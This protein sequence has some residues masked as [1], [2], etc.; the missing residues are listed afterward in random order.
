MA[1]AAILNTSK[2]RA[3]AEKFIAYLLSPAAQKYFAEQTH[4]YPLVEGVQ[5]DTNLP[6]L[7]GL[8]APEIDLSNLTDLK[9]SLELMRQTG[10]L[11]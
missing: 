8:H 10:I 3:D 5:T 6:P 1:G 11:P 7:S 4:E 9:G 2:N